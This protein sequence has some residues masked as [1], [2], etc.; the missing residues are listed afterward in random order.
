MFQYIMLPIRWIIGY[1][2]PI[3]EREFYVDGITCTKFYWPIKTDVVY[4]EN[5]QAKLFISPVLHVEK[6]SSL[7]Q[8]IR[9][10]IR[11]YHMMEDSET[12]LHVNIA[13]FKKNSRLF[14]VL[15]SREK[16]KPCLLSAEPTS[17]V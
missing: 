4:F 9:D 5:D 13:V 14:G 2:K 17:S 16:L 3:K 11:L 7:R 12:K 6:S 15:C 10:M 8:E 1:F